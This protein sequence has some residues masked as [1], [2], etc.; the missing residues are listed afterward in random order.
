[1]AK[2][3]GYFD[4]VYHRNGKLY[5][6]IGKCN[7]D[8]LRKR[9]DQCFVDLCHRDMPLLEI[10]LSGDQARLRQATDQLSLIQL[11]AILP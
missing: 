7:E 4:N 11:F 9:M 6:K 1:M 5:T 3:D 2:L 8:I 10:L